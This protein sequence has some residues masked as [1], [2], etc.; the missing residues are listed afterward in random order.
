MFSPFGL[1]ALVYLLYGSILTLSVYFTL[2]YLLPLIQSLI[3]SDRSK[4]LERHFEASPSSSP[5]EDVMRARLIAAA[6]PAQRFPLYKSLKFFLLS[7]GII[8]II[9]GLLIIILPDDRSG[10]G[11]RIVA[12]VPLLL[13]VG[14]YF[15]YKKTYPNQGLWREL[16]GF[17]LLGGAAYTLFN[18]YDLFELDYFFSSD[19]Y[20]Y[21]LLSFGLFVV[22]H[23]KSTVASYLFMIVVIAGSFFVNSE[24]G[25]NWMMFMSHFIWF[26]AV[27]ILSFWLPRLRAAKEIEMREII[28]GIL[29]FAMMMTLAVNCTSGLG[30]LAVVVVLP[31]LYIFSK[32]HFKRATWFGGRPIE[33]I[34]F[35]FVFGGT[36]ALSQDNIIE[37]MHNQIALFSDFSFHKLVAFFIIILAGLIGYLMYSDQLEKEKQSINLFLV[38]SP[39][40]AFILV[41]A[42]GD[43]GAQYLMNGFLLFLG[44]WYLLK[45]L[46]QKDVLKLVLA[47]FAIIG[48]IAIRL[49]EYAE[50]LDGKMAIGFV[51]V[52]FGAIAL[53]LGFFMRS[54]WTVTSEEQASDFHE[55]K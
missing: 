16:A 8:G 5:E 27:A 45:G 21:L 12:F 15:L 49:V 55:L 42:I 4:W 17:F 10:M 47:S 38:F 52:L 26:F 3:S 19:I 37:R 29:F 51:V 25:N 7:V 18:V 32:I 40:A 53:S 30:P 20:L 31:T 43:Y 28:F 23:L 13:G 11:R 1:G 39:L 9:A 33:M 35:I 50:Y 44:I 34:T 2:I 46:E 48:S 41:Y 14:I 24:I 36:I 6:K 22:H 54:V